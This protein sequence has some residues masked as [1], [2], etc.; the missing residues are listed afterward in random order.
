M[1]NEKRLY[2][3]A[4]LELTAHFA[5]I[6]TQNLSY[7]ATV[8]NIS[9]GGFCFQAKQEIPKDTDIELSITISDSKEVKIQVCSEWAKKI[10][11]TGRYM[12]GVRIAEKT[13]TDLEAFLTFYC[14]QISRLLAKPDD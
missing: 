7:E 1:V 6:G 13:S 12:I 2:Q 4:P 3:R 5:I 14:S 8:I 10:G 9:A 11:D